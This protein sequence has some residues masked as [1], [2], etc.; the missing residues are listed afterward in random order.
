MIVLS[1]S[2]MLTNNITLITLKVHKES[3]GLFIF[4]ECYMKYLILN[5]I[6]KLCKSKLRKVFFFSI[7]YFHESGDKL[8]LFSAADDCK[9]RIWDLHK[10]RYKFA[11][12]IFCKFE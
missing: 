2:G 11:I 6:N 9:I 4:F 1:K 5:A 10:S 8:Q 12:S 3:L 7:L